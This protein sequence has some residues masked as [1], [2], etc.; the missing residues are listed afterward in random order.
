MICKPDADQFKLEINNRGIQHLIHFTPTINLLSIMEQG[1]LLCRKT[2][3]DLN[4]EETDIL[5]YAEFTDEVRYDDKNYI[6]LSV[7]FPNT[8]LFSR[9]IQKTS[10][11]PHVVWCVLKIDPKHIYHKDTLF[12]ITNAANSHNKRTYGIT[13]D[14]AK[15]RMMFAQSFNVVSFTSSRTVSRGNLHPKY[16]TD[17]QAEVLIKGEIPICDV[18]QVC[19]KNQAELAATKAALNDFDTSKFCVDESVFSNNRL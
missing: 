9:F 19:F 12:S 14:I 5:D 4:I 16:P 13:G 7:S 8:F 6:N 17:V 1:K 11:K 2:L 15:F 18:L 10:L 3:E